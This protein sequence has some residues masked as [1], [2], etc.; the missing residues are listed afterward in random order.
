M[1]GHM[2]KSEFRPTENYQQFY[3]GHRFEPM[4][5]PACYMADLVIP[6][7]GWALEVASA[8]SAQHVLDLCCLDGFALL[9]MANRLPHIVGTGVD[10]SADGV[11]LAQDRATIKKLNLRFIEGAVED[12]QDEVGYDLVLLFEAIE[13]FTDVDK[14]MDTIKANMNPGATLLV[15]TPDAEGYYGI[16]NIED[17]CHL[18]VYSH[19]LPFIKEG[20][21]RYPE[22]SPVKK[23]VISLP[24][25]LQS[26]GFMVES[27]DVWG[28]LVHVRAVLK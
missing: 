6:R 16:R 25:Y 22:D 7:V 17:T 12:F 8:I 3:Q 2:N 13:H 23:P 5:D 27:T 4:P 20:F 28:E 18:Q 19:K 11:R 15:S 1:L 10:L 14:V 9:S 24:H 21:P 26:Q